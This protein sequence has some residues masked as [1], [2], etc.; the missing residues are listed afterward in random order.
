M[1][2]TPTLCWKFE[3]TPA[4]KVAVDPSVEKPP[5]IL[6]FVI[7][8]TNAHVKNMFHHVINYQ[9]VSIVFAIIIRVAWQQYKQYNNLPHWTLG[10]AQLHNKYLKLWAV[11]LT[12][13]GSWL[14]S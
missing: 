5:T 7:K 9:H 6:T 3:L 4:I 1:Q 8:P 10:T 2:H 14:Y 11:P 13:Y 12:H